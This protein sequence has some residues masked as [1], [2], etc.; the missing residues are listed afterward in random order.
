MDLYESLSSVAVHD[1][2]FISLTGGGGKTTLMIEWASRLRSRGYRVLMTTTTKIMSPSFL[3]YRADRVFSSDDILSFRPAGPCS[4][5]YAVGDSLTNKWLSPPLEQF[6]LLRDRF[7]V[8]INEADGSKRLPVKVHTQRD[9]VVPDLTTYT[10]SIFGLWALGHSTSE[11][12]FGESR[13]LV[14]DPSYIQWLLDDPEGLLKG[15]LPGRRAIVFNGADCIGSD[16]SAGLR[17]L[18]YPSDVFVCTASEREGEIHE[19][20]Q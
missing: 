16:V 2:A 6:D 8:I 15:S 10:V 1:G 9:P 7:D 3:D 5:L 14:V 13:N 11:V 19:R 4:V 20:I 18:V 17:S 12:A